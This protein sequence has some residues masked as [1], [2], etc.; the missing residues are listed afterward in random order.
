MLGGVALELEIAIPQYR[1][2]SGAYQRVQWAW[3]DLWAGSLDSPA[4][5]GVER[6]EPRLG[7]KPPSIGSSVRRPQQVPPRW[8]RFF[9]AN[10]GSP[11]RWH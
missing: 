2:V 7:N 9:W 4:L 3:N 1:Y 5:G 11:A 10:E 6:K 8:G